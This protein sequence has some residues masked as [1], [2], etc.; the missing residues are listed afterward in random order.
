[1]LKNCMFAM[2]RKK[3]KISQ[4]SAADGGAE[5][6]KGL[7]RQPSVKYTKDPHMQHYFPRAVDM[8]QQPVVRYVQ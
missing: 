4:S 7:G 6:S 2:Y 3:G 5:Q 1:M 8:P